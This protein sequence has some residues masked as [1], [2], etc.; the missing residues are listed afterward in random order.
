[1][2]SGSY[3]WFIGP[4]KWAM[5][6]CKWLIRPLTRQILSGMMLPVGLRSEQ[7]QR[8]CHGYVPH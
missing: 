4:L 8:K 5:P 6:S 3:P 7:T 1:M 2:V